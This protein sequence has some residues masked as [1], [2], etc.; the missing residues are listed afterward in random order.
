[1]FPPAA[2]TTDI[3]FTVPKDDLVRAKRAVSD[4]VEELGAREWIVDESIAKIS[5]GEVTR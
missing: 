4:V 2:G 1:M 3:S 5:L